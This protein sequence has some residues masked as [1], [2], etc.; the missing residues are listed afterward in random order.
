MEV[1]RN[2]DYGNAGE[3]YKKRPKGDEEFEGHIMRETRIPRKQRN[4]TNPPEDM[5]KL[6]EKIC[7]KYITVKNFCELYDLKYSTVT[8]L[9]LKGATT[10]N[11]RFLLKDIEVLL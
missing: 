6:R 2:N 7:K 11:K 3:Y 9:L 1:V 10:R 8:Q 5:L 4:K